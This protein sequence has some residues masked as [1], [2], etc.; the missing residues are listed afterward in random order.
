MYSTAIANEILG[1]AGTQMII[2]TFS[3]AA[4]VILAI[5]FIAF[6]Q[7][8]KQLD[9]EAS[10]YF[11]RFTNP[12]AKFAVFIAAVYV[13]QPSAVES[14]IAAFN[15]RRGGLDDFPYSFIDYSPETLCG[16]SKARIV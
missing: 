3:H 5:W 9:A 2:D 1:A 12:Q 8:L 10:R 15:C 11:S 14:I 16:D 7:F 4:V 13:F 6:I